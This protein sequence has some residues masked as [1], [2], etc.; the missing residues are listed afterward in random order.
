M[1]IIHNIKETTF[2]FHM[3][4]MLLD[5]VFTSQQFYFPIKQAP[6]TYGRQ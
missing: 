2:S 4:K 6:H 1:I 5:L 3:A